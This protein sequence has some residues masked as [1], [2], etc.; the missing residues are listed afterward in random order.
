MGGAFR[1]DYSELSGIMEFSMTTSHPE[2]SIQIV[3]QLFDKLSKYYID[4]T[5]VKQRADFDLIKSKYDSIQT[6]L[7][8]VQ[9]SLA[10]FEDQHQGLIRRQDQLKKKQL[11]GEE[12]KLATM[13]GEVER[14]Y[15]ICL[16]YTSP[17][18]RDATLSRMPSSA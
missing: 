13:V 17:S 16:L 10:K 6:R 11:Q 9:Y 8:S 7:T 3:N 14:Q 5:A 1:S 4:K 18:P 2:L 15:Q 12:L